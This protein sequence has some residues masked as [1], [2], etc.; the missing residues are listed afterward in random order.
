MTID[1]LPNNAPASPPPTSKPGLHLK[2]P[3][4]VVADLQRSLKLYQDILGFRLDYLSAASET[5]YLY[6]VFKIPKHGKLTFATLSTEHELRALA[7]TEV[8]GVDLPCPQPP[9][10]IG[11]V[12]QVAELNPTIL[13]IQALDL[14]IM[15][16]SYFTAPP[17]LAFTEQ[18]FFDFDGHLIILYEVKIVEKEKEKG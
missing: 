13:A 5:S 11:L 2:R 6:T 3:C 16:P 12:I 15:P 4:L 8:K 7:L 17:N 9:H 10:S 18:G 1:P 14:E